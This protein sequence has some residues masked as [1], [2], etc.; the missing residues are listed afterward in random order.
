[1]HVPFPREDDPIEVPGT[2]SVDA[3]QEQ[4]AR[5]GQEAG[6]QRHAHEDVHALAAED[7]GGDPYGECAG[8]ESS[9]HHDVECLPDTPT[10]SVVHAAD[11]AETGEFAIG[12]EGKGDHD[13][14][15]QAE[16]EAVHDRESENGYGPLPAVGV[17]VADVDSGSA[18]SCALNPVSFSRSWASRS[19]PAMLLR[20]TCTRPA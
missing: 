17:E 7:P 10:V 5:V 14:H 4:A 3:Q 11:G 8:A 19:W 6:E 1:M 2:A 13:Q 16:E 15:D 9:E 18:H 20:I 12:G